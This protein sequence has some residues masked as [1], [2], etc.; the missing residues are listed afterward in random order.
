[1]KVICTKTDGCDA[2]PSCLSIQGPNACPYYT[3]TGLAEVIDWRELAEMY[4][5]IIAEQEDYGFAFEQLTACYEELAGEHEELRGEYNSLVDALNSPRGVV[6]SMPVAAPEQVSVRPYVRAKPRRS[7]A[8]VDAPQASDLGNGGD[9]GTDPPPSASGEA[10]GHTYGS[11]G[12]ESENPYEPDAPCQCCREDFP[13]LFP[14]S[15][16]ERKD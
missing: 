10:T 16:E 8:T 7:K 2:M 12:E 4:A 6:C 15:G 1:M 9:P 3:R 13:E 11:L 5:A 14:Q